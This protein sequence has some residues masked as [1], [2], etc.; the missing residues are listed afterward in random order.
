MITTADYQIRRRESLIPEAKDL[1]WNVHKCAQKWREVVPET[2]EISTVKSISAVPR[3]NS[4]TLYNIPSITQP[5]PASRVLLPSIVDRSPEL[6]EL[7]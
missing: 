3:R 4:S 7:Q 1:A 6:H 2:E 5:S